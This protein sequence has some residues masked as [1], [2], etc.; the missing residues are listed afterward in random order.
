MGEAEHLKALEA[1]RLKAERKAEAARLEVER[2]KAERNA[3]AARLEAECL[4][5]KREA[6]TEHKARAEAK[7]KAFKHAIEQLTTL[8]SKHAT[9]QFKTRKCKQAIQRSRTVIIRHAVEL[10][11][12]TVKV[13]AAVAFLGGSYGR[14]N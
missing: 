1:E 5:A 2:L 13:K 12:P 3:E 4:K 8:R 7:C 9:E 6:E 11:P 10:P 14:M